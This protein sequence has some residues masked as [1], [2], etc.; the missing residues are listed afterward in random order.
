M[1]APANVDD[2]VRMTALGGLL[3]LEELNPYL[4][5]L[6]TSVALGAPASLAQQMVYDGLL[7]HFH[8]EQLLA[9][10]YRGFRLGKYQILERIGSGGMGSVFLAVH[11]TLKRRVALKVLPAQSGADP[12]ILERFFREARAAAALDH[13]NIA[14]AYD[15]DSERN[16]HFLVMEFVDGIDMQQLVKRRGHLAPGHAA[17]Y[18]RQAADGLA[19]AHE[20]KL[21]HRDIKPGNLM[22][23]RQGVVKILDMGL[24]RF[25]QDETD[26]LTM[27]VNANSVLG[28]AD[29]IA[30]EQARDS[31]D[32]DIR[33][34][35]YSLGGTLFYL[36]TGQPPFSGG[37]TA[38]KLL[39]HQLRPVEDVRTLQAGV[40]AGL[41]AVVTRMLA[42]EPGQRYQTPAEVSAA[43]AEFVDRHVPAPSAAELPQW[44]RAAEA[45][46]GAVPPSALLFAETVPDRAPITLKPRRVAPPPA[47]LVPGETPA[48]LFA[49]DTP[50]MLPILP[51]PQ[52]EQEAGTERDSTQSVGLWTVLAAVAILIAAGFTIWWFTYETP[53]VEKP[54]EYALEGEHLRILGKSGEFPLSPQQMAGFKDGAWSGNAQLWSSPARVGDWA[55]LIVPVA[56]KGRY[57]LRVRLTKAPD[58]G[59]VQFSIEGKP[60]GQPFDGY[61]ADTVINAEPLDLGIVELKK[62]AA[63]LRITVVGT[64]PKSIGARH[65]WGIDRIVLTPEP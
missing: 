15:A 45:G 17:D 59:M 9:G 58:Y 40:P 34:D 28:T 65:M 48:T 20:R 37:G 50:L 57:R 25:F 63:T 11:S 8:A 4:Q 41:A 35:I 30:P 2:F 38:Q 16:L 22:L 62:G 23:N 7:T 36:L 39:W 18:V 1:T 53:D 5:S 32:V 64:N 43:L 3:P 61:L 6:E 42:K 12:A 27:D 60:L 19:H 52:P 33:A 47:T 54:K 10:K 14:R 29:Y 56:V 26:N 46:G 55:D 24:A 21:I 51:V 44:C 31:H 13:P 49:M